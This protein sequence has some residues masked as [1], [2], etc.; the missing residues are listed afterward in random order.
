MTGIII[1]GFNIIGKWF[2]TEEIL[3]LMQ[4]HIPI[5]NGHTVHLCQK[6]VSKK[7]H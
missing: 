7:K 2:L 3:F 4:Y 1:Q 6:T 5:M